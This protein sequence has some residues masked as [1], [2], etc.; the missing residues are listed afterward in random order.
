MW[1]VQTLAHEVGHAFYYTPDS[2]TEGA[3]VQTSLNSEGAATVSNIIIRNEI[4]ANSGV[5]IGLAGNVRNAQ[6]YYSQFASFMRARRE[7]YSDTV[8]NIGNFYGTHRV[9]IG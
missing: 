9:V 8:Q 3:F 1:V 2:S 6:Y 4:L 7:S 5:N